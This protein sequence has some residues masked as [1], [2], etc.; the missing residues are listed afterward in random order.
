VSTVASSLVV[1][2][3]G[4]AIRVH[5]TVVI[6]CGNDSLVLAHFDDVDMTTVSSWRKDSFD[7]P[8]KLDSMIQP[9]CAGGIGRAT[10]ILLPRI[11]VEE[12]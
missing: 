1:F 7:V 9:S 6:T 12:K 4:A 2:F 5:Q 11:D 10:R 8:S 3:A